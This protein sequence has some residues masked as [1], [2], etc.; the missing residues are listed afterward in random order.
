MCGMVSGN[1]D[2]KSSA[3]KGETSISLREETVLLDF[4]CKKLANKSYLLKYFLPCKE[5]VNIL[6]VSIKFQRC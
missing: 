6:G 3:A 5:M 1:L 2:L 4:L